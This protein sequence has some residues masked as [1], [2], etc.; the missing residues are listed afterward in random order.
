M[1]ILPT[2][3]NENADACN[4]DQM[5][6]RNAFEISFKYF[7]NTFKYVLSN[8]RFYLNEKYQEQNK[9]DV[10]DIYSI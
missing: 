9:N 2:L 5:Q 4:F 3:S 10:K 8:T 1:Q 6:N 7:S